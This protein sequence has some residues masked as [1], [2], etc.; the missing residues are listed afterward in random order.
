M[1]RFPNEK[2]FMIGKNIFCLHDFSNIPSFIFDFDYYD[3]PDEE[4]A[5]VLDYKFKNCDGGESQ[6]TLTFDPN[7]GRFVLDCDDENF[8][9]TRGMPLYLYVIARHL[10][11]AYEILIPDYSMTVS[12]K[13]IQAHDLVGATVI[14][15]VNVIPWGE[16]IEQAWINRMVHVNSMNEA[17]LETA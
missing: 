3:S 4:G 5:Y 11:A 6:V 2:T 12:V 8:V 14:D 15:L 10:G 13:P 17:I 16:T 9:R 7:E 1:E